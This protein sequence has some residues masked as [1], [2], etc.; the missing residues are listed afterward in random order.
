M[1]IFNSYVEFPEGRWDFFNATQSPLPAEV[2]LYAR[3][4]NERLAASTLPICVCNSTDKDG[5]RT[6]PWVTGT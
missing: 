5:R 4:F 6:W 2:N 3:R 1:A